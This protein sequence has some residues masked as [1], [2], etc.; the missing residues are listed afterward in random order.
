MHP[1]VHISERSD[2]F[3]ILE[4]KEWL[5]EI[6]AILQKVVISHT[7]HITSLPYHT[8]YFS[9]YMIQNDSIYIFYH[10]WYDSHI[11]TKYYDKGYDDKY[12][13]FRE[14]VVMKTSNKIYDY[15][16]C[17]RSMKSTSG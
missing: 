10:I 9:T 1:T 15:S 17:S 2:A 11:K 13:V 5:L 12:F 4:S 3:I 16:L 8:L 7:T 14:L 6:I